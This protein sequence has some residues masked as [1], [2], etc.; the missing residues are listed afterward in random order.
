MLTGIL[1]SDLNR[2][3]AVTIVPSKRLDNRLN[4]KT[5]KTKRA[6]GTIAKE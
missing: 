6:R 2:R 5:S 4:R 3:G 1:E